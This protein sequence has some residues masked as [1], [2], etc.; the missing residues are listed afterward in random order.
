M[1]PF[2]GRLGL[3][4]N[5]LRLYLDWVGITLGL[6][7]L[8]LSGIQFDKLGI[9]LDKLRIRLSLDS[10]RGLLLSSSPLSKRLLAQGTQL[11]PAALAAGLVKE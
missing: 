7:G 6:D 2:G 8:S 9:R 11:A 1:R 4:L 3:R 5:R 10:T